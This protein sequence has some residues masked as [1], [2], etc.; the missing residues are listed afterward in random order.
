MGKYLHF[1]L[2]GKRT[3]F[4]VKYKEKH[5]SLSIFSLYHMKP[6]EATYSISLG[7]IMKDITYNKKELWEHEFI[8]SSCSQ[9]IC[10][11]D[12]IKFLIFE[13]GF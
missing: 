13:D 2:D 7:K 3:K 1:D 6:N 4:L 9:N 11:K 5:S 12:L 8:V 10:G